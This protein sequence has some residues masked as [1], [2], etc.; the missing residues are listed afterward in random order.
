MQQE[1][2]IDVRTAYAATDA[3]YNPTFGLQYDMLTVTG[4]P[5]PEPA[6][7]WMLAAGLIAVVLSPGLRAAYGRRRRYC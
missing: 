4:Q 6:T 2:N 1:R 3:G 5:V 7:T